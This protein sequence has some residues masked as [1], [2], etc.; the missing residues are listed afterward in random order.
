MLEACHVSTSGLDNVA[1]MALVPHSADVWR[2]V[3]LTGLE[4]EFKTDAPAWV[5]QFAGELPMPKSGEVWIDPICVRVGETVG[6]YATGLVRNLASG[7][8]FEPPIPARPPTG[9]LPPLAP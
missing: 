8:V 6:F 4:P 2:Y 1:G 3:P 7:E 5:I 9:T